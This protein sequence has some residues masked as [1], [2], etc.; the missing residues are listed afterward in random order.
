MMLYQDY[1]KIPKIARRLANIFIVWKLPD[2]NQQRLLSK[3]MGFES[4][5]L[6][7]LL[8][9]CKEKHD[10][11]TIDLTSNTPAKFRLNVFQPIEEVEKEE[12]E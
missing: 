7:N 9:L 5:T 10:S 2:L 3:R 1:M 11:I 8:K 6:H 4:D 12:Q